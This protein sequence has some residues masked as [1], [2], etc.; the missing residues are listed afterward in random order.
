MALIIDPTNI[1]ENTEITINTA[2]K[3]FTLNLAGNLS[4]DG[5]TGQALYSF[6][7]DEWKADATKIPY[8]F[9]ME[10]ITPE[11]FEFINGWAPADDATR[12]LL[13]TCGWAEKDASGNTSREYMGF[14]SLGNIDSTSKTVGDKAYY[15]FAGDAS[16]TDFTY[17]GPVDEGVQIFG[18]TS[19]GH[20]GS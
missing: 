3:T 8:L 2:L 10:A 5:V 1:V 16:K 12:K 13:R 20:A 6:F 9:P 14:I 18:S 17:A 7:K 15:A 11:Q 4:A 19:F